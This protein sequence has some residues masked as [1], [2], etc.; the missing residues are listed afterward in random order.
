MEKPAQ[1]SEAAMQTPLKIDF[2]GPPDEALR[3]VIIEQQAQLEHIFD[4]LIAGH[5][6]VKAPQDHHRSGGL[7]EVHIH[8]SLP[9]G[10]EVNVGRSPPSDERQLD[11][12][13]A[14]HDAFRRA[15]RQ[16]EEHTIRHVGRQMEDHVRRLRAIPKVHEA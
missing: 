4:R 15:R 12:I 14:I 13:F 16:L 11:A 9:D 3:R 10:G 6:T 5:V 8:L 7:Y 1:E 2:H